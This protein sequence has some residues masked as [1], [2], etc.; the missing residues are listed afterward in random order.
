MTEGDPIN[1][2]RVPLRLPHGAHRDGA[3]SADAGGAEPDLDTAALPRP[4]RT[5]L[6]M[7]RHVRPFVLRALVAGLLPAAAGVLIA[8]HVDEGRLPDLVE[9]ADLSHLAPPEGFTELAPTGEVEAFAEPGA[10]VVFGPHVRVASA[11]SLMREEGLDRDAPVA[12]SDLKTARAWS[13]PPVTVADVKP[14]GTLEDDTPL[15]SLASSGSLGPM[16]LIPHDASA[17]KT[18]APAPAAAA[19]AATAD[20]I[21]S[22]FGAPRKLV[23]ADAHAF[24]ATA[25]AAASASIMSAYADPGGIDLSAP[26][27][28]VLNPGALPHGVSGNGLDHWWSDRPLPEKIT[29]EEEVQC[30][31]EAIYFEARSEP[32]DGQAAV[33]QVIINRVKNPAYPDSICGVVYQNRKWYNRCQFSFACDRIKDVVNDPVAWETATEI[34]QKYTAG[35]MW[36]PQV[37]ASTHYHADYVSPRWAPQMKRIRQI[38]A[39][40][41]YLTLR[42]DWT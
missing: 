31:A 7:G 5:R 4:T 25:A 15:I 40:I 16:R 32:V 14:A 17:M 22:A 21:G 38:G 2:R 18:E 41:F 1:R 6:S 28:A 26:F 39:H 37:G 19:L 12:P 23:L 24:H 35:E 13:A 8:Q 11:W 27:Q 20:P 30:L 42:G 29:A 36:L 34:A 3:H 9:V 33:A 10:R